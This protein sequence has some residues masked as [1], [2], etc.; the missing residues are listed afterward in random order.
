MDMI[1]LDPS[2][3]KGSHG[4]CPADSAEWPVL[5]GT[6]ATAGDQ[7]IAA[8]DV[9]DRLLAACLRAG[10]GEAK[11]AARPSRPGVNRRKGARV[12]IRSGG[13]SGVGPQERVEVDQQFA[14]DGDVGDF[15]RFAAGAELL[16]VEDAPGRGASVLDTAQAAHLPGVP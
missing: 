16:V 11:G 12:Q 13:D 7:A 10:G 15:G 14:G 3:V 1:S 6:G 8:T 9:H 5:I 2:L 4:T